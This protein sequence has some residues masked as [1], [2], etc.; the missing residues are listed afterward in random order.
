MSRGALLTGGLVL[1]ALAAAWRPAPAAGDATEALGRSMG[2]V[3]VM[4]IDALST[5]AGTLAQVIGSGAGGALSGAVVAAAVAEGAVVF[6]A[7]D[8]SRA[9]TW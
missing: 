2:G 8:V 6:C 1:L 7:G 4:V 5:A 3:R 9:V